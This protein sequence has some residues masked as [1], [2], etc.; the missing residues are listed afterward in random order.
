M[1]RLPETRWLEMLSPWNKSL[2]GK[3]TSDSVPTGVLKSQAEEAVH[4]EQGE[5][6]AWAH[7]SP[8]F[9]LTLKE[10]P[11]LKNTFPCCECC[12]K[13]IPRDGVHCGIPSRTLQSALERLLFMWWLFSPR[14]GLQAQWN[15]MCSCHPHLFA[16]SHY[17]TPFLLFSDRL[18]QQQSFIPRCVWCL[19]V[20]VFSLCHSHCCL[21]IL[22][23]SPPPNKK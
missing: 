3:E 15:S 14:G 8:V 10:M 5:D 4:A 20:T 22:T 2:S 1:K 6:G 12:R 18:S 11:P 9:E 16:I 23:S 13:A 17:F 7:Q 19:P 21:W